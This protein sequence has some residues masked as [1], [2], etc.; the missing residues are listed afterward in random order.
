MLAGVDINRYAYAGNDPVNLSDPNGHIFE[1]IRDFFSSL[2]DRNSRNEDAADF[3]R[4]EQADNL[5]NYNSGKIDLSTYE[6]RKQQYEEQIKKYEDRVDESN[7]QAGLHALDQI[8][9]GKTKKTLEA[10]AG[11]GA[12]QFGKKAAE[13]LQKWTLGE[14]KSAS[15]WARQMERRGWT[16]SQIEDA[17]RSG[18]QYPA[19]NNI[20][21]SNGA[22]SICK[23]TDWSIRC[24]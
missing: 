1:A 4:G 14:G 12:K 13:K 7:V 16:V 3:Y 6:D 15:K 23:L 19:A 21:P 2:S 20:N 8:P 9:V 24:Y 5:K 22:T 11:V 18:K 17:I 10:A